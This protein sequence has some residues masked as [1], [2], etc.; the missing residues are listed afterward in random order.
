MGNPRTRPNTYSAQSAG[1]VASPEGRFP[2][3]LVVLKIRSGGADQPNM[4]PSHPEDTVTTSR[5]STNRGKIAALIGL[6]VASLSGSTSGFSGVLGFA[7]LYLLLTGAWAVI[8]RGPWLGKTTRRARAGVLP[9][10]WP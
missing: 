4:L 5:E 9:V 2:V 6:G 3:R 7:G 10:A 1:G 8:C